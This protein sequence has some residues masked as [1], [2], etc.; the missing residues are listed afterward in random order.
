MQASFSL[1]VGRHAGGPGWPAAASAS[2]RRPQAPS[3]SAAARP[4]LG[5]GGESEAADL[6]C[7]WAPGRSRAP[8]PSE[9]R[10]HLAGWLDLGVQV[11]LPDMTG[12]TRSILSMFSRLGQ[13]RIGC[14]FEP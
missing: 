8:S 13:V 7:Q 5:G 10:S 9:S 12:I 6:N 3:E 2:P 11:R 4:G 14:K 1:S